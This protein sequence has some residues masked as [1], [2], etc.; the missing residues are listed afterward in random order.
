MTGG[1]LFALLLAQPAARD[2]LLDRYRTANTWEIS[3]VRRG[4]ADA[5]LRPRLAGARRRLAAARRRLTASFGAD[6]LRRN[7]V[8]LVVVGDPCA[9]RAAAAN[10]VI[11]FDFAV[12]HL[13]TALARARGR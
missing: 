4:C 6:A 9:N 1:L 8:P 11:E 13:E 10:A 3:A 2:D 5:S 7:E 12:A